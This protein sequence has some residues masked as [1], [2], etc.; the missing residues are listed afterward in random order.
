LKNAKS[1][2][3]AQQ[4]PMQ[5]RSKLKGH[6]NEMIFSFFIIGSSDALPTKAEHLSI[7]LT[8]LYKEIVKYES[9]CHVPLSKGKQSKY[10]SKSYEKI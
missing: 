7:F 5:R 1:D 10:R 3:Q 6:G 9:R 8:E 2:D 4:S